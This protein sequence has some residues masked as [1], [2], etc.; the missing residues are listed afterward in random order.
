MLYVVACGGRS[1]A[2]LVDHLPD[3]QAD[4]WRT[5]VIATPMGTNF[6]DR[7]KLQ[8]VSGHVVRFAYKQPD[9]PDA[10]PPA[11]AVVIAPATFNTINKMVSGN[12]DTLALGIL[13]EAIGLGLPMVAVPTPNAALARHPAFPASVATLR[14]WGIQVM[15]DPRRFP[16]PTPNMGPPAADLFPWEA[17]RT[18]LVAIRGRL[19]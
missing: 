2:Q 7:E 18:E 13:N 11:D 1:A 17:L 3:W 14:S 5:C 8:Q 9:E 6:I 4:G 16:L 12:S 15:F 19:P 10:L